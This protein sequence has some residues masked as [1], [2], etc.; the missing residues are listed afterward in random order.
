MCSFDE[1]LK[2]NITSI[3][4]ELEEKLNQIFR[5]IVATGDKAWAPSSGILSSDFVEHDSNEALEEIEEENSISNV[6]MSSQVGSDE[7]N[8]S[9]KIQSEPI[10]HMQQK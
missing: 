7:N 9:P 8:E 2:F 6:H 5:G 4:P 10:K 3:D 1:Y